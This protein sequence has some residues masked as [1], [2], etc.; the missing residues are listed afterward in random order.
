MAMDTSGLTFDTCPDESI[1]AGSSY[2]DARIEFIQ[3][4][5]ESSGKTINNIETEFFDTIFGG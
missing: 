1:K 5:H 3:M 4:K 2:S